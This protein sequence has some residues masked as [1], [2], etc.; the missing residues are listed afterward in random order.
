MKITI[1]V[2]AACLALG[3]CAS[4]LKKAQATVAV[5]ADLLPGHYSNAAQADAD[6]KAGRD[7]HEAKSIDIVR[8][9]L[10]L[11]SDYAFYAQEVSLD[12]MRRVI[13][14]RLYTFEA[15]KDGTVVQRLYTFAQPARWRDGLANPSVFTGMMF[16]DTNAL[17]GC[18]LI[19]KA[20]SNKLVAANSRETCRTSSPSVGTMRTEMKVE[21]NGDELAMAE[22]G[23]TAGGKLV[24]GIESD[25]FYRFERGG[26]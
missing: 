10:P 6:A 17:A 26:Q 25:P 20:E 9:D 19:W 13:S 16:K 1:A 11:L 2:A 21:L 8:L 3:G 22:L 15:V 7:R 18:D 23:Y 4:D 24:Q 14:Q 5:I 12:D